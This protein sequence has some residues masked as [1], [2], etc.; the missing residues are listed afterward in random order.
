MQISAYI[1]KILDHINLVFV[2][3]SAGMMIYYWIHY[4]NYKNDSTVSNDNS[5]ALAI[6][7][8]GIFILSIVFGY[9]LP[10][11]EKKRAEVVVH[12]S[13]IAFG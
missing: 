6:T 12:P 3:F 1:N 11:Y 10:Y 7:F 5:E 13:N 8:T 9:A 4:N 2:L